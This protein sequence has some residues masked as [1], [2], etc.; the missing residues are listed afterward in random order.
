VTTAQTTPSGLTQASVTSDILARAQAHG[1]VLSADSATVDETGWDFLVVQATAVD[2]TPWIL[3][4]PRRPP[5]V[6]AAMAEAKLIATLRGRLPVA[7][8]DFR[9]VTPDLIAYPRLAGEPAGAGNPRTGPLTWCIDPANPPEALVRALG[10]VVAQLH[11]TPVSEVAETGIPVRSPDDARTAF[12]QRLQ[13]GQTELGMHPSW[14]ERGRRWLD[15]DR[16]WAESMVLIHADLHPGHTLVDGTG[17]LTG[18][19]DWTDAEVGDPGQEF[20]VVARTFG[21]V[22]FDRL[23]D[24]YH[25]YG[26]PA[27][28]GLRGHV[29]EALAFWPLER[30]TKAAGLGMPHLF[31]EARTR[32]SIPTTIPES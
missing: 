17:T 22:M 2:G 7:V 18:I 19:L 24:V 25:E 6:K 32:Y 5:V 3:R 9:I 12:A 30:A 20:L 21:Q 13:F 10:R 8:P 4:V 15:D 31:D 11:T 1:L 29:R 26:G 16:L 28:P 14:L 23:V 27:W